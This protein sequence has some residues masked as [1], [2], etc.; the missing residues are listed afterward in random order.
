MRA[1]LATVLALALAVFGLGPATTPA[2]AAGGEKVWETAYAVYPSDGD[3]VWVCIEGQKCDPKNKK[4][5]TS[6]RLMAIQAM[7]VVHNGSVSKEAKAA[8]VPSMQVDQCHGAEA[9]A[10]LNEMVFG[11]A[12]WEFGKKSPHKLRLKSMKKS[13]S[14][15]GRLR[16]T[17]E[18]YRD[19]KWIDVQAELLKQGHV[20]FMS[21]PLALGETAHSKEYNKLA[22]IA[23]TKGENL[24][25]TDYCKPGPNQDHT[26]E[27]DVRFDANGDDTKNVNG[28]WMRIRN[29]SPTRINLKGWS[30]RTAAWHV[31]DFTKNTYIEPNGWI[32]VHSG[33]K[34]K[35][36]KPRHYY[37]G[38]AKPF[39]QNTQGGGAYLW[40]KDGDLRA[41]QMF[42]CHYQC[43]TNPGL[44][45]T[46]T[47]ADAKGNDAKN[48]NGEY[49][50]IKNTSKAT[51]RL[52]PYQVKVG[53]KF[54]SFSST[55]TIKAGKSIKIK[56][57]KGK[58]TATTKYLGSTKPVMPNGKGK[59]Q[60]AT[61][62]G[63]VLSSKSW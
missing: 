38:F 46:K 42:N 35:T 8:R 59:A 37:M 63:T 50:V 49:V 11:K 32:M 20:M 55:A 36:V 58:N 26:L 54:Y 44:K 13:S 61:Y 10:A 21:L 34:P 12:T 14:S 31:Y 24:W 40:D 1:A 22:Q 60:I 52:A 17:V 56:M 28:E 57:G 5:W 19:G 48:V 41:W 18:V 33:K 62:P 4:T 51:I 23:A 39:L 43:A 6:V 27:I 25:D 3:T 45:I 53:A 15:Y 30:M 16:R 9:T 7:E 47:V 29:T 2:T